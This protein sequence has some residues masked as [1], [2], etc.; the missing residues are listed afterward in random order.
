MN[1]DFSLA[2]KRYWTLRKHRDEATWARFLI[3]SGFAV[4]FPSL[5]MA[6]ASAFGRAR[7]GAEGLMASYALGF[8]IAFLIHG[9]YRATERLLSETQLQRLSKGWPA[10]VFHML[11]PVAGVAGGMAL[12][13]PAYGWLRDVTVHTPFESARGIQQFLLISLTFSLIGTFVAWLLA[14]QSKHKQALRLQATEARL[15]RLQAQIEPHFLFNSLAAVQ[16]LIGPAPE[17]AHAMLEHF[18]DYLR[19]SLDTLRQD[20]CTLEQELQAAR[21]YL[22]LMQIR[23]NDRLRFELQ[24]SAEARAAVLPPLLRQPLVENAIVHGLEGKVEGGTLRLSAAVANHTLRIRVEDDGLGH[25]A[26]KRA[27][28]GQGLALQNIRQRL[29]AR[30]DDAAHLSV[31]PSAHGCVAELTLPCRTEA[32][33]E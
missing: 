9:L 25:N 10:A 21:S 4:G 33:G 19:S 1:R 20:S 24:A 22:S 5:F 30:Y 18:T 31:T 7:F 29:Q 27:T 26:R 2:W 28:A 8:V 11:L 6:L 3:T 23:M 13:A 14:W 15:L 17:R 32:E 12:F 16:S